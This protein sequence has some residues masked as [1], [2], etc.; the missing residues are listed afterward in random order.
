M[1]L[2]SFLVQHSWLLAAKVDGFYTNGTSFWGLCR[3]V[4]SPRRPISLSPRRLFALSPCLF[5]SSR[6]AS[7]GLTLAAF[8]AGK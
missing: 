8:R 5:Y 7:I 6:K 3:C 4:L 2:K 1:I